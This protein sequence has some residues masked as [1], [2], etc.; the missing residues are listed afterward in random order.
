MLNDFF[1]LTPVEIEKKERAYLPTLLLIK[2]VSTTRLVYY[3]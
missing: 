2:P 3:L 1:S